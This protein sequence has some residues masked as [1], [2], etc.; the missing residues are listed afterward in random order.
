MHDLSLFME[1]SQAL[2]QLLPHDVVTTRV[3][4][5]RCEALLNAAIRSD[6]LLTFNPG[7]WS[8]RLIARLDHGPWSHVALV[9]S[10]KALYEAV[11]PRVRCI[12]LTHYLVWPYRLALLRHNG[13]FRGSKAAEAFMRAQVGMPYAYRK[14][15]LQML[16]KLLNVTHRTPM[17]NDIAAMPRYGLVCR[18]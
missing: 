18:V 4:H 12:G 7:S 5:V 8:S 15:A 9:G 10:D 11:P 3:H 2:P 16:L 6:L 1:L 13:P 17:P 14:A